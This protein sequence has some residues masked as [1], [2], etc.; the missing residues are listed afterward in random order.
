MS[1]TGNSADPDYYYFYY[2]I[3][4]EVPCDNTILGLNNVDKPTRSVLK[5]T[6]VLGKE[7]GYSSNQTLFYLFDDGTV[8]KRITVE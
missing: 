8:E 5:V 3:E 6:D 2:N 4:V 1:I 7:V